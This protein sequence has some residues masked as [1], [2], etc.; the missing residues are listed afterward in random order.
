MIN[1]ESINEHDLWTKKEPRKIRYLVDESKILYLCTSDF[2]YENDIPLKLKKLYELNFNLIHEKHISANFTKEL[3]RN[4]VINLIK[5][6][7]DNICTIKDMFNNYSIINL[8]RVISIEE[9]ID[10]QYNKDSKYI[11]RITFNSF[12]PDYS[13]SCLKT[14][15]IIFDDFLSMEKAYNKLIGCFK[16]KMA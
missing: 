8:D 15:D 16:Y 9:V 1:I 5:D 13:D 3:S 2:K 6:S 10:T 11:I 4:N 14:Y 7:L 12:E